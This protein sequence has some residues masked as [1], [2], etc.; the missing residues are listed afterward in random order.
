MSSAHD[1][2]LSADDLGSLRHA[3]R[4]GRLGDRVRLGAGALL[5]LGAGAM[6]LPGP[7]LPWPD[8][9]LLIA[10]PAGA[11][12]GGGW[13]LYGALW[14]RQRLW[15]PMADARRGG[16]KQVLRGRL[17][18]VRASDAGHLFYTVDGR[19]LDLVPLAG[20][21]ETHAL[22]PGQPLRR[23]AHLPGTEVTLHWLPL[24]TDAGAL[25]QAHYASETPPRRS[26]RPADADDLG[27]TTQQRRQLLLLTGGV[28]VALAGFALWA[29]PGSVRLTG[30]ALAA[31]VLAVGGLGAW[32][33]GAQRLLRHQL[34]G[35]VSERFDEQ[36]EDAT[37]TW[38]RV[39]GELVCPGTDI[40]PVQVGEPVQVTW[41]A[42]A[43]GPG[44]QLVA[45]QACDEGPAAQTQP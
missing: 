21:R 34:V 36:G 14:R 29:G 25:L 3:G 23:L 10:A 9:L 24:A 6:A 1:E 38:Y 42:P 33:H 8:R 28:T 17:Q 18:G 43:R 45:F 30:L 35:T 37:L 44:G 19:T 32:R 2:P 39:G 7:G 4:A 5:M 26:A 16:R 13:L 40:P 20:P 15:Q 22:H 41:L 12:V 27:P 11:A 31:L